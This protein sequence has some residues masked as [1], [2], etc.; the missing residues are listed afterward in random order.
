M[1]NEYRKPI[2]RTNQQY[3]LSPL[4]E[5]FLI[6]VEFTLPAKWP[7]LIKFPA[8]ETVFTAFQLTPIHPGL[9]GYPFSYPPQMGFP[10]PGS[11]L[12]TPVAFVVSQIEMLR[13]PLGDS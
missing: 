2:E 11:P 8:F 6:T 7:K 3:N 4:E 13:V 1:L 12:V 5:D 9:P 10:P